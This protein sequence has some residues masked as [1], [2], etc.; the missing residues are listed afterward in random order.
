LSAAGDSGR[1]SS[2]YI[3]TANVVAGAPAGH[4]SWRNTPAANSRATE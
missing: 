3:I 4:G 1:R 2:D